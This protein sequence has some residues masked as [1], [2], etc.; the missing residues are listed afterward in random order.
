LATLISQTEQGLFVSHLPLVAEK[1]AD[2]IVF[3]GHLARANPHF[4][5]LQTNPVYIIFQGPNGY[6]TPSWYAEHDVPTWNYAVVHAQGNCE[7]ME[8]PAAIKDCLIKLTKHMESERSIPWE[9]SIP[10]DLSAHSVLE[11]AIAGFKISATSL[12]AK[13]KLSQNRRESDRAGVM[14]GLA[15]EDTDMARALLELMR[16]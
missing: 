7:L 11:K 14:A 8:S 3:Y 13:F 10:E 9:F 15:Q 1:V 2:G 4:K 16:N 6:V 5:Y 12:Q